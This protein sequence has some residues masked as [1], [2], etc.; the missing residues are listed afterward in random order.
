MDIHGDMS[1]DDRERFEE[2]IEKMLEYVPGAKMGV[3]SFLIEAGRRWAG[4]ILGKK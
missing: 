4:E 3:G 1:S 2:A